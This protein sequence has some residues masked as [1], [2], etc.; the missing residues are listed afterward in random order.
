MII[1]L[2]P[3]LVLS[4]LLLSAAVAGAQDLSHYRDAQLGTSIKAVTSAIGVEHPVTTV[5]HSRP[6]LMQDVDWAPRGQLGVMM[7]V[8]PVRRVVF[9]FIDDQL[10]RVAVSYDRSRIEGLT[11]EDLVEALTTLYGPAMAS[12]GRTLQ[13]SESPDRGE[14]HTVVARWDNL[15]SSVVLL[16]G[17]Y[18]APVSL[19]VLDKR[20]AGQARTAA[21]EGSRLELMEAPQ[22]AI[23]DRLRAEDATRKAQE[24]VRPV[25]KAAFKP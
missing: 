16:R 25:N 1:A 21:T 7:P 2:R 11:D 23:D 5:V 4:A 20:L 8:D 22:R 6:A 14:D 24:K 12:P 19:V 3:L 13:P 9:S 17:T 18:L 15:E 10:F